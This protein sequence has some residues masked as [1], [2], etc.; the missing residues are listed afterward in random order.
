MLKKYDKKPYS[1]KCI[2]QISGKDRKIPLDIYIFYVDI[3]IFNI[4]TKF[5]LVHGRDD[6]PFKD[7][8]S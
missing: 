1:P 4:N 8:N 2:T 6:S 7:E 3:V 5:I